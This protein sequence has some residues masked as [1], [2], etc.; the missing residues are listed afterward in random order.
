MGNELYD[1]EVKDRQAFIKFLHALHKDFLNDPES[2]ENNT[3]PRI[4]RLCGGHSG[5]L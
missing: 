4:E 1:F 3:L 5:V 2:W